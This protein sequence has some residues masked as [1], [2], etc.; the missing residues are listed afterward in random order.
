M[1]NL[2]VEMFEEVIIGPKTTTRRRWYRG[3]ET[4]GATRG[5]SVGGFR[6]EKKQKLLT[7]EEHKKTCEKCQKGESCF[8]SICYRPTGE[9]RSL[10]EIEERLKSE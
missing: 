7:F 8:V 4:V 3:T 5:L 10:S 9:I 2:L 6:Q 1:L